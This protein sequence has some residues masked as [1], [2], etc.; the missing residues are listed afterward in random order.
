MKKIRI[1]YTI[2]NFDT[3]GSGRLLLSLMEKLDK[4]VFELQI[5]CFHTR[6]AFFS[7][8]EK[9]GFPVHVYNFVADMSNRLKGVREVLRIARFFRTLD[10]DIIHSFHYT[11]DYSEALAGRL[12]GCKW[13][14]TKKN[15]S[16][17]GKCENGWKLRTWLANGVIAQNSDMLGA[18]FK[19]H[20]KVVMI[21]SGVD[22]EEFA[23]QAPDPSL[24][25]LFDTPEDKRIV[26]TVANFVPVKG[27]EVL[28]N[29]FSRVA[30]QHPSWMLW[31]VGNHNNE[32]GKFLQELCQ[33]NGIADKTRFLGWQLNVRRFLDHAEIFVIPTLDKG[34]REGSPV[35]LLE[36][37]ANEKVVLASNISGIR[38]QLNTYPAHLFP[39]GDID[40]LASK[41]GVWMGESRENNRV[42]GRRFAEHV[43][44]HYSTA[45]IAA[46]YE[47]FYTKI[48]AER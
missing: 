48:V 28:I 11:S 39:A 42:L 9:S 37:M 44:Q 3:A 21:P 19:N 30:S 45:V 6:G 4:S 10:V 32:Y 2:P 41:L 8:V 1:L 29:A 17:F 16:W 13:V 47:E 43:R 31:I 12:A 34:R 33:Q 20:K 38:D 27:L 7:T 36:A 5:C 46:K 23:S 40:D 25:R 15:M 18:F 26:I 14:Y 22:T 24:R 35:A